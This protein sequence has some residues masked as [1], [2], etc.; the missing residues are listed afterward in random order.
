MLLDYVNEYGGI[1]FKHEAFNYLD[2]LALAELANFEW[3]P[4]TFGMKLTDALALASHPVWSQPV[5]A[6]GKDALV[7]MRCEEDDTLAHMLMSSIRYEDLRVFDFSSRF[8]AYDEQFAALAFCF[9]DTT[10]VCF[11]GTDGTYTGWYESFQ[12][13]LDTPV[14]GQT[15]ACAFL[16]DV[17]DRTNGPLIIC[18][19]SK[20]GNLA[21]Y[22]AALLANCDEE[23]AVRAAA[24]VSFDGPG[25]PPEIRNLEGYKRIEPVVVTFIPQSS[26]VGN[27]HEHPKGSVTYVKSTGNFAQQHIAYNW[28]TK[29]TRFVAAPQSFAGKTK[30]AMLD[31]LVTK[32]DDA[33][34]RR[35]IDAIFAIP[36]ALRLRKLPIN[37]QEL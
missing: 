14:K 32:V 35:I 13:A 36:K 1:S 11:R 37:L 26:V 17:A 30:S 27:V 2:L 12:L 28:K 33:H 16:K 18:G 20:G 8:A 6:D 25:L 5:H 10:I 9:E 29:G 4:E 31:A 15:N 19:H 21:E 7:I 24:V 22:A 23:F 3:P 34:K